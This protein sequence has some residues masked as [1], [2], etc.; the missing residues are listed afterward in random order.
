MGDWA[1]QSGSGIRFEWGSAGAG[2]LAAKAACLVIVDVLS[3]TTT[4]SVAV[5]QG[6]RVLPF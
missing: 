6:I 4:V 1:G 3:F 5:R 2:R